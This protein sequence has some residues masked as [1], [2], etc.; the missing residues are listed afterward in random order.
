VGPDRDRF[1]EPGDL[2]APTLADLIPQLQ[3][4]AP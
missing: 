2:A 4:P 3:E 1:L